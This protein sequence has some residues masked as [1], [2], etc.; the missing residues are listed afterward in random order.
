VPNAVVVL[1]P[2]PNSRQRA[3]R[4][5]FT[6]TD[7]SGRFRIQNVPGDYKLFAWEDIEPGVWQ[8]PAV[9][10]IYENRGQPITLNSNTQQ[11]IE[12]RVIQ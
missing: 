12:L 6:A 1:V 7:A 8:D 10:R 4:Y 9:I 3:D 5:A 2:P 11:G